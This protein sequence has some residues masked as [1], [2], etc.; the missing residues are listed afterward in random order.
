[1]VHSGA[2]RGDGI[3]LCSYL[4]VAWVNR[5]RL[6]SLGRRRVHT[7]SSGF[8]R[9]RLAIAGFIRVRVGSLLRALG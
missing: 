7:D 6:V 5:V 1:M 3:H 2:P 8:A 9:A 4:E